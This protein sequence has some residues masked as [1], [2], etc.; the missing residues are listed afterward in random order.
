[1]LAGQLICPVRTG[2][3]MEIVN[4]I[5]TSIRSQCDISLDLNGRLEISGE[6]VSPYPARDDATD[7]G[8]QRFIW[9]VCL[10]MAFLT[11]K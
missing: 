10:C 1:M 6:V 9:Y 8:H 5:Q 4:A 7:H 11:R 3:P 2:M